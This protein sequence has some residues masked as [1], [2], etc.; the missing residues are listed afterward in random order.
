MIYISIDTETGGLEWKHN[1]LLEFGAI[2]EDTKNQLPFDQIP[3]WSVLLSNV[4]NR[5]H[6]SA[7]A[8][9][10][11]GEIFKELAKKPEDRTEK[12]IA[13]QDLSWA[14]RKWLIQHPA[15]ADYANNTK[16]IPINVAGK[17]FGTFD[18]RFLEENGFYDRIKIIQRLIDPAVL[19]YNDDVDD[20]LPNLSVCKQR[21]GLLETSIVHRTIEDAWD[22]IQV[23]RGKMYPR[24]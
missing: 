13:A 23:L 14:F 8:L 18:N 24:L 11:H 16:P 2:I 10:M 9:A 7:Y 4:D 17:N 1:S 12:V 21:A 3:K 22:V 19:Y 15:F 20:S 6:G 5:Y